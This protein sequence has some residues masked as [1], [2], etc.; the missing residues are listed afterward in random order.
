MSSG[1]RRVLRAGFQLGSAALAVHL[2]LPQLAGLEATGR[3]LATATWWAAVSVVGLEAASL[4]AYG[5]LTATVLRGM[6]TVVPLGVA[7]RA[8]F[9]G[10]AVGRT[11]PGGNAAALAL[12]VTA[13]RS[14]G[15]D[16]TRGATGLAAS[17]LLSSLV[18]AGLL[19]I[20]ALVNLA[21]GGTGGR[22]LGVAGLVVA[23]AVAWVVVVTA[24]GRPEAF[25]RVAGRL[26][27][28]VARG[29]LRRR[30]DPDAVAVTVAHAAGAVRALTLRPAVLRRAAA[31][32]AGNWLLDVAALAVVAATVGRG[33]ALTALLLAYVVAQVVAAVPLT[34]GGVGVVE[35]T[36]VSA[37]VAS[38]APAAAAT[39][40]VLGWRLVSHWLPIPVG[41]TL[42][43]IRSRR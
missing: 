26:A 8:S 6:G 22:V 40:T 28:S 14:A 42:L 2:V 37:L 34:P 38:G 20:A 36:M 29:P 16:P 23:V 1:R 10:T 25:G 32:A 39:A 30:L 11:L 3:A 4:A 27:R 33:T 18:L 43:L 31:W 24:R 17:G 41:L 9:V 19:P 7:V 13:L 15:V 12:N 35:A 5:A 21:G